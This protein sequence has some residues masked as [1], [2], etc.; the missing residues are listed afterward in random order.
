MT[1]FAY[2]PESSCLCSNQCFHLTQART[3]PGMPSPYIPEWRGR[4]EDTARTWHTVE[5]CDGH[6][7][8]LDAVQRP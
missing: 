7:A 6:R 4:F 1:Q 8:D 5:A 2:F 3:A